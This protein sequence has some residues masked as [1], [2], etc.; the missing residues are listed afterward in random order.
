VGCELYDQGRALMESGAL[1]E[2]A[3]AFSQSAAED[4]HFKTLELLGECYAK[5]DRLKDA[6]VPLAAAAALNRQ[7]RAPALLAEVF[8][9]LGQREDAI[10]MAR[11]AIQRSGNNKRAWAV[12]HRLGA[13]IHGSEM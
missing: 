8:E 6:I 2:A 1:A 10:E 4:P 7:S 11:L 9:Q 5:L 3:E 13:I 12:L